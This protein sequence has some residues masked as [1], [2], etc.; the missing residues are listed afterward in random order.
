MQPVPNFANSVITY[1]DDLTREKYRSYPTNVEESVV[2]NINQFALKII[3][4]IKNHADKCLLSVTLDE[5]VGCDGKGFELIK[6]AFEQKYQI[7]IKWTI[8]PY[9]KER[10]IHVLIKNIPII[11][12]RTSACQL[13][14]SF[15]ADNPHIFPRPNVL[16]INPPYTF[17]EHCKVEWEKAKQGIG[18]TVTFSVENKTYHAHKSKL[19]M[20][21][22]YFEGLYRS[23]MIEARENAVM[24][25][26]D[27]S[28]EH[29]EAV[30]KF[31]YMAYLDESYKEL[32]HLFELVLVANRFGV[33]KL[34][35]LC[36]ERIH[37][38]LLKHSIDVAGLMNLFGV[39]GQ[40]EQNSLL[41]DVCLMQ[42]ESKH[43][44][45]SCLIGAI[46]KT[47][48]ARFTE[49]AKKRNLHFVLEQIEI[50]KI[51]NPLLN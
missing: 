24:K 34:G 15:K 28:A 39:V 17:T 6:M 12:T 33:V 49:V 31:I 23:Q 27:V 46:N 5:E 47:N 42:I 30:L 2:Q 32:E 18:T 36:V 51:Y 8:I 44:L 1:V 40:I 14:A 29:F 45:K 16:A 4:Q 41:L 48:S 9:P 7:Q 19:V 3:E 21:S 22:T 50:C 10:N 13:T 11:L 37:K 26:E 20:H 38:Y 43:E 25:M 35:D